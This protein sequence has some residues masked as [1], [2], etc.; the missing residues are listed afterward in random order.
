[1]FDRFPLGKGYTNTDLMNVCS[2]ISG[3]SFKQFFD[4]F[5][6]G[7]KP[8]EWEKYLGY[9][10]LQLISIDSTLEPIIGLK[11][12]SSGD[13]IIVNNVLSGSAADSM[14]FITGDE[15]ITADG[16]RTNYHDL[17]ER[18][19]NLKIGEKI[20]L[21]IFRKD[22]YKEIKLSLK[23]PKVPNYSIAKVTSPD[24]LQNS[25]FEDWLKVKW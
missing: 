24:P 18:L 23:S 21:G 1:M 13:K 16:E 12:E 6:Y 4:D 25:I 2:E 14:K 17:S 20:T 5:V 3:K 10:G 8:I 9:A 19:L 15:I 11:L 22:K 7:T